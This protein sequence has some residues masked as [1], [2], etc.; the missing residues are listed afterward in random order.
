MLI[1][2]NYLQELHLPTW[3]HNWVRKEGE[4]KK[5]NEPEG[6]RKKEWKKRI[7]RNT[8]SCIL[9]VKAISMILW[10]NF[11][12]HKLLERDRKG[13]LVITMRTEK[14]CLE[15]DHW[16]AL[17]SWHAQLTTLISSHNHIIRRGCKQAGSMPIMNSQC[18]NSNICKGWLDKNAIAVSMWRN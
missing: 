2:T 7:L 6:K 17:L 13:L 1:Q 15:D 4:K 3:R 5:K 10:Q 11:V 16:K 14:A 9:E 18:D 12:T 8:L